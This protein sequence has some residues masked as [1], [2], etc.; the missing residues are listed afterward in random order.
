MN[1]YTTAQLAEIRRRELTAEAAYHR[2]TRGRCA[3]TGSRRRG[4]LRKP[5]TTFHSWLAAGQ[6]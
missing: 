6:L 3:S 1:P 5:I 2:Q 4:H